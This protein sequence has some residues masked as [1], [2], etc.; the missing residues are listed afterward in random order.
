[1]YEYLSEFHFPLELVSLFEKY[2]QQFSSL[3][4]SSPTLLKV[5]YCGFGWLVSENGDGGRSN[6]YGLHGGTD[7]SIM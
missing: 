6:G 1:M 4:A 2:Q 7:V 5:A 3:A